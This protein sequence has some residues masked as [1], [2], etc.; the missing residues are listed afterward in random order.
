MKEQKLI[1]DTNNYKL[2]EQTLIDFDIF[3]SSYEDVV[4]WIRY[5]LKL[6][7][8]N[9]SPTNEMVEQYKLD[10]YLI[11][12]H[13]KILN[14]KEECIYVS[15]DGGDM[16][17][18]KSNY[19]LNGLSSNTFYKQNDDKPQL[20]NSYVKSIIRHDLLEHSIQPNTEKNKVKPIKI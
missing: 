16:V 9:F 11:L 8:F 20:F 18:Y 12:V 7:E 10:N 13:T 2:D 4:S 1:Y 19:D 6:V 17:F 14:I 15:I 5:N 3:T